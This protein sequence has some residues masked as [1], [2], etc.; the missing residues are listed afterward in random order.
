[1][2]GLRLVNQHRPDCGPLASVVDLEDGRLRLACGPLARWW[3]AS[4]ASGHFDPVHLEQALYP[5]RRLNP[6]PEPAGSA[7]A[8]LLSGAPDLDLPRV[9]AALDLLSAIAAGALPDQNA[10]TPG[11]GHTQLSLAGIEPAPSPTRRKRR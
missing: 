7:V 6:P 9:S 1:M 10:T 4:L 3:A 8:Y 11:D 5:L 2:K